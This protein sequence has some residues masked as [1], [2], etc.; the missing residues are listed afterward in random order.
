MRYSQVKKLSV[1]LSLLLF[2]LTALSQ[3]QNTDS[4]HMLWKV[5]SDDG[6][7]GY[8]V[9]SIHLGKQSMYPLGEAYQKAFENQM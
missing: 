3:A 4:R 2:V 8:L 9:G 6:T 7:E 1:T 5:S